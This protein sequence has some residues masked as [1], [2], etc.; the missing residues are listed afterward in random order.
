[1]ASVFLILRAESVRDLGRPRHHA[2]DYM[3]MRMRNYRY[4][5]IY[6]FIGFD[7]CAMDLQIDIDKVHVTHRFEFDFYTRTLF[8]YRHSHHCIFKSENMVV[9]VYQ[10]KYSVPLDE[11]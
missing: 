9:K 8:S 4:A 6:F 7:T 2:I 3:Q 5:N 10:H 1:M 11:I